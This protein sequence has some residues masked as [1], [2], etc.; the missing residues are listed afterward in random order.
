[1]RFRRQNRPWLG[2]ALVAI[3]ITASVTTLLTFPQTG[4]AA[5]TGIGRAVASL[6]AAREPVPPTQRTCAYETTPAQ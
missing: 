3:I 2:A 6:A 5:K 1:M 4:H